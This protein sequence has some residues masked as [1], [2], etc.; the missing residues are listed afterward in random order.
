MRRSARGITVKHPVTKVDDKDC[1]SVTEVDPLL[2][3]TQACY[4]V[5]YGSG[6]C[7]T[8][9]CLHYSASTD[10]SLQFSANL[11]VEQYQWRTHAGLVCVLVLLPALDQSPT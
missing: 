9:A 10:W 3:H 11:C 4:P 2:E 7:A 8:C 6:E 1:F 5:D